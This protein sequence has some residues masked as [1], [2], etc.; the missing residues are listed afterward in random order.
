MRLI[1]HE[2][3]KRRKTKRRDRVARRHHRRA[4]IN[5][6]E[7]K[8]IYGT[9]RDQRYTSDEETDAVLWWRKKLMRK[10]RMARKLARGYA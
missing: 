8:V 7:E 4:R 3:H 6:S 9:F 2:K 1:D 5:R 10:R